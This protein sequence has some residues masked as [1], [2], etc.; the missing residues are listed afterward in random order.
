MI[1]PLL[2]LIN[3]SLSRLVL[4]TCV[5]CMWVFTKT[6]KKKKSFFH[7]PFSSHSH[8]SFLRL[9]TRTSKWWPGENLQASSDSH[10]HFPSLDESHRGK[11]KMVENDCVGVCHSSFPPLEETPVHWTQEGAFWSFRKQGESGWRLGPFV[12]NEEIENL[13]LL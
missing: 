3:P 8:F 6:G 7:S 12:G 2:S 5:V 1:N 11:S 10:F 4:G 9:I 13:S